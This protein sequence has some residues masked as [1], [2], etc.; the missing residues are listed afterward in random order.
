M[1]E[2]GRLGEENPEPVLG[3]WREESVR[4][5]GGGEVPSC[6]PADCPPAPWPPGSVPLGAE[7]VGVIRAL[8]RDPDPEL[9]FR[10]ARWVLESGREGEFEDRLT[11]ADGG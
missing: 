2:F 6:P 3:R 10:A 1:S 5:A 9:R 4:Q 11:G 7:A 8:L